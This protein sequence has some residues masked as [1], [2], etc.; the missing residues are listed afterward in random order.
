VHVLG[1]GGVPRTGV[2][3]VLISARVS[4]PTRSGMLIGGSRSTPIVTSFHAGQRV[5][6][7]AILPVRNGNVA[8][9]NAS[10]GP[11]AL[12]VDVV[13]YIVSATLNPPAAVSFARYPNDLTGNVAGDSTLM[14]THGDTDGDAGATFVLLDLGAQSVT[15]PLSRTH[16]GVAITRTDPVVRYTYPQL[17][18]VLDAYLSALGAHSTGHHVTV[19]V[20]TNNDGDW[21]A[22][23]ATPRGRDWANLIDGLNPPANVSVI[24]ADDIESNFASTQAQAQAWENAYFANTNADLVFNGA[25]NDC[26]TVF[27]DRSACAFGWTQK[28]YW[29][30]TRHVEHG[31]NRTQV[32]PQI[33]FPVQAVQWANVFAHGGGGLRFI[34]SLTEFGADSTT[35]RPEQGWAA[36]YRALQWQ[37]VAPHVPRLVDITPA[38]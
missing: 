29:Q 9:R 32:L 26:P 28:Q 33:Y 4:A 22:Y 15:S 17:T 23:P 24:G 34:G 10:G 1:A 6:G 11:L 12:E 20:G 37:L 16:P 38:A 3:A 13:G 14:T 2:S 5:T 8:L 19:A 35:Y 36:L 7:A 25:L 27:G 18:T 31:R 21:S 30:L